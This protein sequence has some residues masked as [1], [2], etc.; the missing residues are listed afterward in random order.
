M[1]DELWIVDM[2]TNHGWHVDAKGK[3]VT[4]DDYPADVLERVNVAVE[5]AP[6]TRKQADAI[7]GLVI[8]L[9]EDGVLD[10]APAVGIQYPSRTVMANVTQSMRYLHSWTDD[11]DEELHTLADI[12]LCTEIPWE[13]PVIIPPV[14]Q[15]PHQD[16]HK[17]H[18]E[19]VVRARNEKG[20]FIADDPD[21]PENEAWV[22]VEQGDLTEVISHIDP[23]IQEPAAGASENPSDDSLQG[24]IALAPGH[25]VPGQVTVM[26]GDEG[27]E[28]ETWQT[29]INE[30][31][32]SEPERYVGDPTGLDLISVDGVF[33][34]ETQAATSHVQ[35]ILEIP[36]TGS[37]DQATWDA[38]LNG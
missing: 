11:C 26:S 37:C 32:D 25:D 12:G 9:R 34:D 38:V 18:T 30:I 13:D 21:T 27:P 16:T 19:A 5:D 35:A 4:H 1:A 14:D 33:G 20:H 36:V 3:V 22:E 6:L 28:V 10:K 15:S 24:E 8:A 31:L 2:E 7:R 17:G 23:I 29:V